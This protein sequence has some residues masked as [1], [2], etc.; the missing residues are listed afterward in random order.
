[1]A[2]DKSVSSIGE[3][4]EMYSKKK[5][6]FCH[7]FIFELGVEIFNVSRSIIYIFV[8]NGSKKN[9]SYRTK[10]VSTQPLWQPSDGAQ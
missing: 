8:S 1:M 6:H 4:F 2:L 5:P 3:R 7:Y 9:Y 10:S